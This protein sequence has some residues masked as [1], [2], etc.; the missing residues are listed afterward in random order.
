MAA[1]FRRL[2]VAAALLVLA[3]AGAAADSSSSS[4]AT[5]P[6]GEKKHGGFDRKC[7][8]LAEDCEF[9]PKPLVAQKLVRSFYTVSSD[10]ASAVS[11]AATD[12]LPSGTEAFCNYNA[13]TQNVQLSLSC[14]RGYLS[15]GPGC[16][17][18]DGGNVNTFAPLTSLTSLGLF[19]DCALVSSS[20]WPGLRPLAVLVRDGGPPGL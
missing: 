17:T 9:V 12:V 4:S 18:T 11:C 10:G 7:A 19:A 1:L 2:L 14:P 15:V 8:A 13:A 5:A 16:F 3:T 6:S 20:D